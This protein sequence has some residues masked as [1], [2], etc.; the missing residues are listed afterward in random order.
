MARIDDDDD[1]DDDIYSVKR[2]K[3]LRVWLSNDD[4]AIYKVW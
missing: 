1:D 2:I 4:I 3:T